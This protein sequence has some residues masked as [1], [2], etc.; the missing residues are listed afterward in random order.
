MS[1]YYVNSKKVQKYDMTNVGIV[2][3]KT[4]EQLR[5]EISSISN[6][7]REET[8]IEVDD[9]K[10]YIGDGITLYSLTSGALSGVI[11]FDVNVDKITVSGL[12]VPGP[13]T[14][15][16]TQLIN[17]VKTFAELN[18]IKTVNLT[19]YN[20]VVNFYEKNG[21]RIQNQRTVKDDSDDDSDDEDYEPKTRY[22][23]SYTVLAS[24]GKRKASR[25]AI[26][27]AIRKTSRKTSRKASRK[28]RRKY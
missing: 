8:S 21:F 2:G 1:I 10:G 28:T 22:D 18:R 16:G 4:I 12:C 3:D 23:M 14:G 20:S 13:S 27:K 11:N 6:F 5:S 17:A 7:C 9:L 19:C 15:V 24:G 25:K 26:R